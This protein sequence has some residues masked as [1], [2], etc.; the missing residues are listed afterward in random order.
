LVSMPRVNFKSLP[1]RPL[2]H[3]NIRSNFDG[4]KKKYFGQTN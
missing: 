2:E 3:K 1:S 4:R